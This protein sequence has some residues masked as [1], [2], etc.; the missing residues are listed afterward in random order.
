VFRLTPDGRTLFSAIS[1]QRADEA[2]AAAAA[3]NAA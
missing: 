3:R 2:A 1:A